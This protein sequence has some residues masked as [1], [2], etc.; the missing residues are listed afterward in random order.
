MNKSIDVVLPVYNGSKYL[1][2]CINSVLDQINVDFYLYIIDDCSTDNSWEIINGYSD[3]RII[4][5]RNI[6]NIGLFPTLNR[7]MSFG[8]SDVIKIWAQDDVMKPNCLIEFINYFEKYHYDFSFSSSGHI[9]ADGGII[10]FNLEDNTPVNI[11]SSYYRDICIFNGSICSNISNAAISRVA[12]KKYGDFNEGM[13][14]S[15]DHEYWTRIGLISGAIRIP[16][17]LMYIR[18]HKDQLSRSTS[19]AVPFAKEDWGI[20][21][22]LLRACDESYKVDIALKYYQSVVLTYHF[23]TMI[24]LLF[25]LKVKRA[26][27]MLTFIFERQNFIR[28]IIDYIKMRYLKKIKKME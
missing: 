28:I 26:F 21:N 16:E 3:A 4:A 19:T 15:G 25:N 20:F 24:W 13:I 23:N 17:E 18:V 12:L 10:N 8:K 1:K 22:L 9:N 14:A 11:S 2:Q 27:E 5:N 6:S 7:L